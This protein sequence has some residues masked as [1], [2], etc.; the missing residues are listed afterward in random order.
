MRIIHHRAEDFMIAFVLVL[1]ATTI[2]HESVSNLDTIA[3]NPQNTQRLWMALKDL[4]RKVSSSVTPSMILRQADIR[5]FNVTG[6]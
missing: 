4:R 3:V 6:V 5:Y 2:W 1:S